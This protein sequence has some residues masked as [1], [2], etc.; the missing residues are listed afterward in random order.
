MPSM[1]HWQIKDITPEA[2]AKNQ[3]RAAQHAVA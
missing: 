2:W 1:T 3:T